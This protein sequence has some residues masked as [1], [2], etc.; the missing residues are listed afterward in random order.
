MQPIDRF[1]NQAM[2]L[3]D[4]AFVARHQGRQ[5]DALSL[6]RDALRFE[7]SA[8]E[9]LGSPVEPTHSVLLRSAATLALDCNEERKAEQLVSRAL[10][11]DPPQEIAEEL[12]DIL[13]QVNFQRHLALRG[14]S[15]NDDEIQ[16][17]LAG[18]DVGFGYV[19]SDE[20]LRRVT[21]SKKLLQRIAERRN[22]I[23]F[24]LQGPPQ[25]SITDHYPVFMSIPRAASYAV[26]MKLAQPRQQLPLVENKEAIDPAEIV[27]EFMELMHQFN[28]ANYDQIKQTI[29]NEEYTQNFIGL[30]KMIAPDGDRVKLVGL[31]SYIQGQTRTVPVNMTKTATN[32]QLAADQESVDRARTETVVGT[33]RFANAMSMRSR[34]IKVI[35]DEE[36]AHSI[37][38]PPGLMDDIVRPMW[39]SKVI[40]KGIRKRNNVVYLSDINVWSDAEQH[41]TISNNPSSGGEAL[42]I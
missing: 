28:R 24:R 18:T 35:D 15:L 39:G 19:N 27:N 6:S 31:T 4:L 21:D 38:V 11:F 12:R 1:H 22:G 7:L 5:E 30:A 9:E 29:C 37:D 3:A 17:T 32:A 33:L 14:L 41:Q 23:P 10:S 16:L 25:K 40:V 26:T 20:Y 2:E 36:V 42:L 8:I 34:R 13:E